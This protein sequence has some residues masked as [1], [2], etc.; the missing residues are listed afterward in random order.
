M[1]GIE[2]YKGM[3]CDESCSEEKRGELSIN[4]VCS[5]VLLGRN[6]VLIE[7]D[8]PK[9]NTAVNDEIVDWR[10]FCVWLIKPHEAQNAVWYWTCSIPFKSGRA[11]RFVAY[12]SWFVV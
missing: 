5:S 11:L 4:G 9:Y 3:S 2:S 10:R 6:G 7:Y 12:G 8:L 1:R